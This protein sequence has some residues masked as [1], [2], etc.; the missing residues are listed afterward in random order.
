[1]DTLSKIYYSIFERKCLM[2]SKGKR[3]DKDFKEMIVSLYNT[4]GRTLASLDSEYGIPAATIQR[5]VKQFTP[6]KTSSDESITMDE[7]MKMKKEMVRMQ[8]E[9]EILKKAMAILAKK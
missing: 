6:I 7:V 5:W 3:Y 1:M 4:T 2:K 8:E 9:N